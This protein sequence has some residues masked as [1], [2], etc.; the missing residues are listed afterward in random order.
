MIG[1][2]IETMAQ[3]CGAQAPAAL[4]TLSVLSRAPDFSTTALI[5]EPARSSATTSSWI[6]STPSA[7]VLRRSAASTL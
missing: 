6:S 3:I 1:T 4:I 7:R 2:V 5:N